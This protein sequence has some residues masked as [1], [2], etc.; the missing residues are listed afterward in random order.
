M[1]QH[2]ESGPS[3]EEFNSANS[4]NCDNDAD[5]AAHANAAI[6]I[7]NQ[8]SVN[9][10]K[11]E[12][13]TPLPIDLSGIEVFDTWLSHAT[14]HF[15]LEED[16]SGRSQP[17]IEIRGHRYDGCE[18]ERLYGLDFDDFGNISKGFQFTFSEGNTNPDSNETELALKDGEQT[19]WELRV[20]GEY[21]LWNMYPDNH[22]PL[23]ARD[24]ELLTKLLKRL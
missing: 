8:V 6:Y 17:R 4:G 9:L 11:H 15:H 1:A 2:F 3:S 23:E 13:M 12:A 18:I 16:E 21:E 10:F 20:R 22:E 14:M 5:L 24:F 19:A 7:R